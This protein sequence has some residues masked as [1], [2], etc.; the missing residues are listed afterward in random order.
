M[1]KYGKCNFETSG[2]ESRAKIFVNSSK[3]EKGEILL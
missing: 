2:R 1:K 3:A